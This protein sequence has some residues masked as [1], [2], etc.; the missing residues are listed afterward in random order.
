MSKKLY[1]KSMEIYLEELETLNY[2]NNCTINNCSELITIHQ[3]RKKL[4]KDQKNLT[5]R[6]IN[7]AKTTITKLKKELKK[8][9]RN[10]R[11]IR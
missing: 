8:E 2:E 7:E 11:V 9:K 5:D 6:Q 10:G 1:L 3:K 4:A